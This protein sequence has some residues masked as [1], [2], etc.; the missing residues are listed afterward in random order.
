MN[1][2][3]RREPA[4]AYTLVELL[5]V[6]AILVLAVGTVS[7]KLLPVYAEAR[8]RA[9]VEEFQ[10]FENEI[11]ARCW[12]RQAPSAIE[13]DLRR[14]VIRAK[15][16]NAAKGQTRE[17]DLPNSVRMQELLIQNETAVNR[18]EVQIHVNEHGATPSYV[19]GLS[20]EEEKA[21]ILFAGLTGH[22]Q[23]FSKRT[24][25]VKFLKNISSQRADT[26]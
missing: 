5:I 17:I 19:V 6:I 10:A 13:Y 26:D 2:F 11:R 16:R 18:P 21:W 23:R 22:S 24:D 14:Q 20:W 12:R 15:H 9:F 8:S 7:V 1:A 25:V 4:R 3:R